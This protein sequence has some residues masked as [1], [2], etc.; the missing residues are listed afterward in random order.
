[1]SSLRYCFALLALAT[2]PAS[3]EDED[4][5]PRVVIESRQ[6]ALRDIGEAFKG[7]N[8]ALK[9]SN[10][11]LAKIREQAQ[12]IESLS[13][14]QA[15]WFPEGTGQD[16]DVINAA[17]DEIWEQPEKF[18]AGQAAMSAA[19]TKLVK[20]AAGDDLAAIKKQAQALGKTCKACHDTFREED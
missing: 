6:S 10:P 1:M 13:K 11:A 5:D 17:K 9:K 18:K 14:H 8:D 7:I 4:I 20:I 16:A 2:V 15:K 12:L 19:A 3:A